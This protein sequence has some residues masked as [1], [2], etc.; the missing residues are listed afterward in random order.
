MNEW[1]ACNKS[2]CETNTAH[3]LSANNFCWIVA[4][5]SNIVIHHW[6]FIFTECSYAV[7]LLL[8]VHWLWWHAIELTGTYVHWL[9]CLVFGEHSS[10]EHKVREVMHKAFWDVLEEKLREDPPDCS[11]ALVLLQ[12]VKEVRDLCLLRQLLLNP[13]CLSTLSHRVY[14]FYIGDIKFYPVLTTTCSLL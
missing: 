1:W 3:C 11:H 7:S 13:I 4:L 14:C 10:I 2:D 8:C 5:V 6:V 9:L 12:E